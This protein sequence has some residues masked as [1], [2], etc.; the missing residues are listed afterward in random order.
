M[1][2]TVTPEK[3]TYLL[4]VLVVVLTFAGIAAGWLTADAWLPVA[5]M[6]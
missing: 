1:D 5:V 4:K 3:R 2:T 6:K